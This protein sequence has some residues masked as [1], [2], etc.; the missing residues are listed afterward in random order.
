M[1]NSFEN[2]F[3]Q[4]M[5]SSTVDRQVN[6]SS[7]IQKLNEISEAAV[8]PEAHQPTSQIDMNNKRKTKNLG[9]NGTYWN[10]QLNEKRSKLPQPIKISAS[11]H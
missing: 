10:I 11:N 1:P 5:S 6:N 3:D 4:N 2:P 7:F 9:L 8:F